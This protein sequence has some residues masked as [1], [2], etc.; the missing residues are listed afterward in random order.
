MSKETYNYKRTAITTARDLCYSD[1]VIIQIHKAKTEN[2]IS[3]IMRNARLAQE[4]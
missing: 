3:N 2:E 1:E 4:V